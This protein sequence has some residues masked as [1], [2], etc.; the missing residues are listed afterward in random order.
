MS[1]ELFK[2][3]KTSL[4]LRHMMGDVFVGEC[5]ILLLSMVKSIDEGETNPIF[6]RSIK[7]SRKDES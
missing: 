3:I 4:G 7:E 2:E 5:D 1:D 6:L